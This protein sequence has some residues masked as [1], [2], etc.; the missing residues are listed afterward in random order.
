MLETKAPIANGPLAKIITDQH[1]F[2]NTIKFLEDQQPSG[3]NMLMEQIFCQDHGHEQVLSV[4]QNKFYRGQKM[5]S[6]E[7]F[8][9]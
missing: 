2:D 1:Q 8:F 4:S 3:E 7:T 6:Y 9:S 5:V